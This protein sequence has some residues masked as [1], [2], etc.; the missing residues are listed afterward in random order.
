MS[1]VSVAADNLRADPMDTTTYTGGIG[2]GAGEGTETDITYQN[3]ISISRKVTAAG[4]FSGTGAQHDFT[5]T[6]RKTW[7]VKCAV[8]N[9]GGI[10]IL[11]LRFGDAA[12]SY[13]QYI[14]ANN[15]DKLYPAKGGFLILAIDPNYAYYDSTIGGPPT[16]SV[17]DYFGIYLEGTTSKAENLM[18]DA[19]DIGYGLYLTGGDGVDTDGIY[20]DFVDDDEGEIANGRFGYVSTNEG[21]L[22]VLGML[23]RGATT[24]SGTRTSVATVF[25]DIGQTIVFPD[26][27]AAPGFS[28]L[29]VD[30]DTALTVISDAGNSFIGRGNEVISDTRP[31]LQVY[32]NS[33]TY[34]L[35]NYTSFGFLLLT[36]GCSGAVSIVSSGLVT[37]G[38]ADISGSNIKTTTASSAS[39][40]N[41]TSDPNTKTANMSYTSDGTNHALELGSN[42]PISISLTNQLYTGYNG[43]VGSNLIADSGPDDA[44]I[45]NDS[46]KE[47]T[48]SILGTGDNVSIKNGIGATTIIVVG[49]K[50]LTINGLIAG[51]S[52]VRVRDG[53]VTLLNGHINPNQTTQ[54]QMAFDS[55][56][57]ENK[58]KLQ[59]TTPG[60][61]YINKDI[62]LFNTDV[63]IDVTTEMIPDS[64]WIP[65]F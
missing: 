29:T 40:W 63:T 22:N 33:G 54:F 42:T 31:V 48:I 4:F 2:G 8:A 52:E 32:G 11:E 14:L 24:I 51:E 41:E 62:T 36:S 56:A 25:T 44:T 38:G 17:M 7:I 50:I 53:S 46:G 1:V 39:L 60:Y 10:T 19:I 6:G 58:L 34:I 9:F 59:I 43:S 30:L 16:I 26:N 64:S 49:Q 3:G 65:S 55:F 15:T 27:F 37:I 57:V 35:G 28:G 47:I 23:V 13:F 21:V 45:F 18:M 61:D 12:G 20:Q 5:V